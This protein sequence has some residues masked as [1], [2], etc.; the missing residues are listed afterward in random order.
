MYTDLECSFAFSSGAEVPVSI[1]RCPVLAH[2]ALWWGPQ[3]NHLY[4]HV[5]F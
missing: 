4:G 3:G 1:A 5:L 2:T